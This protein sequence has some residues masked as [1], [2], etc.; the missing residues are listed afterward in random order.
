MAQFDYNIDH[1]SV[2]DLEDMFGLIRP[3]ELTALEGVGS[4][5]KEKL[6]SE[7]G[8]DDSLYEQI[9]EFV[10]S[11]MSKMKSTL[12]YE[13]TNKPN[14]ILDSEGHFIIQEEQI[15]TLHTK[16]KTYIRGGLNPV[17]M[18]TIQRT[19]TFNSKFRKN[20]LIQPS[21]NYKVQ[22]PYPIKTTINLDIESTIIPPSYFAIDANLGN[23]FFLII[24]GSASSNWFTFQV[25]I[26]SGNYTPQSFVNHLNNA[27]FVTDWDVQQPTGFT[28][29]S[30]SPAT[31]PS[32][33]GQRILAKLDPAS[34]RIVLYVNENFTTSPPAGGVII[35]LNLD[36]TSPLT[37]EADAT[38]GAMP[39]SAT[40]TPMQLGLGW[41]M[42]Y[43]NAFYTDSLTYVSESIADMHGSAYFYVLVNDFMSSTSNENI[44]ALADSYLDNNILAKIN[45]SDST[46]SERQ[47]IVWENRGA[48]LT[49]S[50]SRKYFGPV[51]IDKLQ[52][53]LVDDCGR[54]V[55]LNDADW[56]VTLVFTCLYQE[57]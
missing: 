20:R 16:Q 22:L 8:E 25:V 44:G 48:V 33:L 6:L 14:K 47:K 4:S 27:I 1:Y 42:G 17:S 9:T 43:R 2:T 39:I 55:N 29:F 57:L 41:M 34:G 56:S 49:G 28:D 53:S 36:F 23:N 24:C 31:P 21:G 26:P 11:A 51:D 30:R 46:R 12:F 54:Q 3:Y 15:P 32:D 38:T 40:N 52:F 5:L 45:V 18:P 13:N 19:V 7:C 50:P 37:T 35:T 10:T